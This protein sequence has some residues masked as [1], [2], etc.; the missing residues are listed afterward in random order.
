MKHLPYFLIII[1]FAIYCISTEFTMGVYFLIQFFIGLLIVQIITHKSN[2][3]VTWMYSLFYSIY[4][5]L[6]LITQYEL[7]PIVD[8]MHYY[9]HND[10]AD[11]FYP[12]II[13]YVIN[14]SWSNL[15][16]TTLFSPLFNNYPLSALIMGFLGKVGVA[17][18]VSNLRLFLRLHEFLFTS[19]TVALITDIPAKMGIYTK[20]TK[21]YIMIF[22]LCSYLYITSAIFTR[23]THVCLA[24]ALLGYVFLLPECKNRWVWFIIL[25]AVSAG[26]RPTNG[27]L[28][29]MFPIVY[30]LSAQKR[31]GL[32]LIILLI[33][34]AVAYPMLNSLFSFGANSLKYYSEL[35]ENNVGGIFEKVYSLPFPIN[36]IGIAIYL[37]L[38]PLPITSVLS[39]TTHGSMMNLPYCLSPYIMVMLYFTTLYMAIH[40]AVNSKKHRNY[41]YLCVFLFFTI[42]Y[43]SPEIRR[44][45]AAIP[46]LY[47]VFLC[48]LPEI[49]QSVT[50][51]VRTKAWPITLL[52]T[53]ALT[54]YATIK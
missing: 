25:V 10:A 54:I 36:Q 50:S 29:A 40:G 8:E 37:L 45:F 6:T 21:K 23:D 27:I 16:D 53:T 39:S 44:A 32:F 34:C 28:A 22:S 48:Y 1:L 3:D 5:L 31:S 12:A 4:G 24:Y 14:A 19:I 49:P 41:I 46:C 47:M 30:Y 42:V 13:E 38:L 26:F 9:I 17:L 11:A 51:F 35:T 43:G 20:K 2:S 33:A 18:E 15:L 52:T 7:I